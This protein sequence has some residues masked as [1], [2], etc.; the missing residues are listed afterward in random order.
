MGSSDDN[1][2]PTIPAALITMSDGQILADAETKALT[3]SAEQAAR[4]CEGGQMSSFSCWGVA[5]D[6]R[7]LPDFAGVGGNIYSCY[8]NGQYGL[9]SG[10]SMATPVV[11]AAIGLLLEK[12]PDM[13]P[14]DVKYCLYRTAKDCGYSKQI[15]GWGRIDVARMMRY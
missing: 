8:D 4:P 14:K 13:T 3:V 10:T 7:L 9:M 15:Q 11:S 1:Y 6:L 5:P 2:K 12:N